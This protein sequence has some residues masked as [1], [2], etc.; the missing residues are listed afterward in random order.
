MLVGLPVEERDPVKRFRAIHGEVSQLK[1]ARQADGVDELG[2]LL[3]NAPALLHFGLGSTLTSPNL[4]A[5]LICTNVVGPLVPLYCMG[6][7]MVA[8][9]P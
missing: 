9:Y 1:A 7:R 2:N 5:N 3:T 4:L 6:H 8:H